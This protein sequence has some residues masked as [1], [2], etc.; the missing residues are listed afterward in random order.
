MFDLKNLHSKLP[1]ELL[2][3]FQLISDADFKVGIVGGWCRDY[4]LSGV[5]GKDYDL[6][7]RPVS[8]NENFVTHFKELMKS[9]G[10][11]YEIKKLK[12]DV[13]RLKSDEFECE[14]TLPRVEIFSD[15]IHHSNFEAKFIQDLD[16]KL[17]FRRRDFTVNAIMFELAEEFKLIDPLGGVED[18]QR[19]NLSSCSED[20]AKDPVRFLRAVRF[21]LKYDFKISQD[22][23]ENFIKLSYSHFST[24]YLLAEARKSGKRLTFFKKLI[25]LMSVDFEQDYLELYDTAFKDLKDADFYKG[26]LFLSLDFYKELKK[27]LKDSVKLESFEKIQFKNCNDQEQG[28]KAYKILTKSSKKQIDFYHKIGHIDISSEELALMMKLKVDVSKIE[29]PKRKA[30]LFSKR[31]EALGDH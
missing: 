14:M 29:E 9:L 15:K 27:I 20:F 11:H 18:L 4:L 19:K 30:Y 13:F 8:H 2:K 1:G 12:Y 5:I 16:Y 25:G 10:S 28:H 31:L 23:K 6:E 22:I 26:C 24:Y 3:I 7:L 17:G 21:S